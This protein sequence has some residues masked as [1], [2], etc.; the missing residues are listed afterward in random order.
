MSH[1]DPHRTLTPPPEP[2]PPWKEKA[3]RLVSW[4]I[5]RYTRWPYD[6]PKKSG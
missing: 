4:L 5:A 6:L 3:V 1:H 2:L